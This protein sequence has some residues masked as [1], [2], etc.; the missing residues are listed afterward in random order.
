MQSKWRKSEYRLGGE[1]KNER[2]SQHDC[3]TR[4]IVRRKPA[5]PPLDREDN[6]S[7][8]ILFL[9]SFSGRR[10][11]RE[12]ATATNTKGLWLFS[13]I[14]SLAQLCAQIGATR[15]KKKVCTRSPNTTHLFIQLVT[16]ALVRNRI[17]ALKIIAFSAKWRKIATKASATC[18]RTRIKIRRRKK[19]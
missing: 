17:S 12:N 3:G 15:K 19:N 4:A 9:F 11:N 2:Q 1:R 14:L 5:L 8:Y 13:I 16:T 7:F 10:P 18:P 6:F